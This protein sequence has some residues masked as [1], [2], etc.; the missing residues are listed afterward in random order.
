MEIGKCKNKFKEKVKRIEKIWRKETRLFI[1]KHVK[2]NI[3]KVVIYFK[4]F[5]KENVDFLK[6]NKKVIALGELFIKQRK[7]KAT[8]VEKLV[9]FFCVDF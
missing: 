1:K 8:S 9:W 5:Q 4:M 7:V 6:R 3:K 2:K